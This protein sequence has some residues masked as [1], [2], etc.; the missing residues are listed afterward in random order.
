ME[1]EITMTDRWK[2]MENIPKFQQ[3]R[4]I[5]TQEDAS[6]P[7]SVFLLSFHRPDTSK[8][9]L[10]SSLGQCAPNKKKMNMLVML[11]RDNRD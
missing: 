7:N 6:T 2:L 3:D 5:L 1:M 8:V 11:W 9:H 10:L 4:I